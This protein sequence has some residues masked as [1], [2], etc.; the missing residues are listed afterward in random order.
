MAI[1]SRTVLVI[2]ST[3][4]VGRECVRLLLEDATVSRVVAIV[5]APT[6]VFGKSPKLDMR[7]V[8]FDKLSF[9]ADVFAVDQIICAIGTT[10]RKTPDRDIYRSIDY[11]YPLTAA[12]LGKDGGARHYLVVTAL[13][14]DSGSRLFYN[15]LKG[16]VEDDLTALRFRSLTIARPSVLIGERSEARRSEILAWK[17]APITP[18][19]Y[20]P[21]PAANVSRA[22]VNAARNDLPGKRILTNAE[23]LSVASI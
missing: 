16:E 3:G 12:K 19:K 8:D 10:L 13:G 9:H 17:L 4:L 21:V 15:R 20:K 1:A 11:G 6:D 5:R 7:T 22:L 18:R 14:A 23:M 2:G